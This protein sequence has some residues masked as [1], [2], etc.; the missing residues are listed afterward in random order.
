[1][2]NF[3]N[4]VCHF[5]FSSSQQHEVKSHE[6]TQF[7]LMLKCSHTY[8]SFR[9]CYF[10]GC[11]CVVMFFA[12]KIRSEW[13]LLFQDYQHQY[14]AVVQYCLVLGLHEGSLKGNKKSRNK[15]E[16]WFSTKQQLKI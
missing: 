10:C 13:S 14:L 15:T 1:M 6:V 8:T 3:G 12:L 11:E 4:L 5:I 2:L 7:L 16:F 9:P